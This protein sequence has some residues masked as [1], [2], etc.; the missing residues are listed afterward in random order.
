M[1]DLDSPLSQEFFE[2]PVG[3]SV[4]QYHRTA[5]RMTSGGNRNP[6]NAELGR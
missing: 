5:T 3:K 2:V 1:V 6:A 4:A